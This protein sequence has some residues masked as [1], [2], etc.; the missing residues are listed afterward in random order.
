M[1][2]TILNKSIFLK[3]FISSILSVNLCFSSYKGKQVAPKLIIELNN[4]QLLITLKAPLKRLFGVEKL[5]INDGDKN[6]NII[7]EVMKKLENTYGLLHIPNEK[8][9]QCELKNI[10]HTIS[11]KDDESLKWSTSY[12][13]YCENPEKLVVIEA[14]FLYRLPKLKTIQVVNKDNEP[15]TELKANYKNQSIGLRGF[16]SFEKE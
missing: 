10:S 3:L 1:Q 5:S 6:K 13:Y 7:D 15:I 8:A 14:R 4:K 2:N 16:T 9:T 11:G 12:E